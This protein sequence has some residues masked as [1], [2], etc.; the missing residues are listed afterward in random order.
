MVSWGNLADRLEQ[1]AA[2][3]YA[4]FD[5]R[6]TITWEEL[7]KMEE[8]H[9]VVLDRVYN[10]RLRTENAQQGVSTDD[11]WSVTGL[12]E[13]EMDLPAELAFGAYTKPTLPY[14]YVR[15]TGEMP[16]PTDVT[17]RHFIIGFELGG[18]GELL[19]FELR[20]SG[21][22]YVGYLEGRGK[23]AL[24]LQRTEITTNLPGDLFT[25]THNW[26]L[27]VNEGFVEMYIDGSLRGVL[28]FG[29]ENRSVVKSNTAPYSI[30]RIGGKP[31]TNMPGIVEAFMNGETWKPPVAP[32]EIRWSSGDPTPSRTYRLYDDEADTL[33]TSGTYAA[34]A[35]HYSHPV[36][37]KGYGKK[38]LAFRADTATASGSPLETQVYTQDGSWRTIDSYD[39][40]VDEFYHLDID[41][42]FPLVRVG[43]EPSADGASIT[44]AEVN[45]S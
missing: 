29:G 39:L 24:G 10:S 32:T 5:R 27:I 34:G 38:T 6:G 3:K 22:S 9:N 13:G 30:G 8:K 20:E 19:C 4:L 37:V 35:V 23:N 40:G 14:G 11:Y 2:S 17:D 45:L 1:W 26:N 44:D 31:P 33:M 42:D 43:Y 16:D 15:Y 28:L 21:G 18:G 41:V 12:A 7:L 36:P 25:A